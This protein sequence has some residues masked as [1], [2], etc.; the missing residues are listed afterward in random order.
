[1]Y[2]VGDIAFVKQ[3]IFLPDG[4]KLIQ[5]P[6][7]VINNLNSNSVL[8]YE[9]SQEQCES[10]KAFADDLRA[11]RSWNSDWFSV[12]RRFFLYG[13]AKEFSPTWGDVDRIVDYT[14]ALE[15]AVVPESELS[16]RR[17]RYRAAMLVSPNDPEQQK[18]VRKLVQ[19]LYDVR[20][21]VVHGSGLSGGQ[22]EWL[23]ENCGQLELR[24]RQILVAAVQLIPASDEE[25][26]TMLAAL[27]DPTDQDRGEFVLQKFQEI[28]TEGVRKAIATKIGRLT[29]N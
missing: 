25:R 12:A 10:W 24:V 23:I 13:G 21:S 26:R 4:R 15:A 6:Y 5:A 18:T 8:P 19:Q 14:T 27:Y 22:R 3:A 7:S 11:S 1:L 29:G 17:I 9:F 16:G 20:S 28:R 2:W